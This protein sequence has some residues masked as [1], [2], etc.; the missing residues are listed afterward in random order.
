MS[1]PLTR[2]VSPMQ[3]QDPTGAEA[4]SAGDSSSMETP[5]LEGLPE[6]PGSPEGRRGLEMVSASEGG[7]SLHQGVDG[8]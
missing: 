8:A 5:S 3:I 2:V 4:I 6:V 7:G 1:N